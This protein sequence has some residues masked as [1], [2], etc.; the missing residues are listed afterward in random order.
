M[1]ILHISIDQ[2]PFPTDKFLLQYW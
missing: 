2:I 1:A